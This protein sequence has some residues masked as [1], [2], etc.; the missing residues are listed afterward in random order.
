MLGR[1]ADDPTPWRE[2]ALLPQSLGLLDELTVEENVGLPSRLQGAGSAVELAD[3]LDRLGSSA[4]YTG[5]P[6]EI[7]LGEQ[8]R[9]ALARGGDRANRAS[10]S[11]TNPS[12]IRT[13]SGPRS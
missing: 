10:C 4:S 8:Q 5:S 9:T 2:V 6:S 13:T 7:S 11:P 12:P 3:L 1:P